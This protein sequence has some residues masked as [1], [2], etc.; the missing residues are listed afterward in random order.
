MV[1]VTV[2]KLEADRQIVGV[3]QRELTQ[4]SEQASDRITRW[5]YERVA[6]VKLISGL[7]TTAQRDQVRR[8]AIDR[9][10]SLYPI[11]TGWVGYIDNNCKI[12]LGSAGLREGETYDESV[13]QGADSSSYLGEV[14]T[15][16]WI[17]GGTVENPQSTLFLPMA[18]PVFDESGARVGL[19]AMEIRTTYLDELLTRVPLTVADGHPAR[20]F[21]V[22]KDTKTVVIG[23]ECAGTP[24]SDA[25]LEGLGNRSAEMNLPWPDRDNYITGSAPSRDFRDVAN[26][27]W[28]MV[29]RADRESALTLVDD[30]TTRL[31]L[32]GGA[33]SVCSIIMALLL[34]KSLGRPLE[35]LTAAAANNE[36]QE[37]AIRTAANVRYREISDLATALD[38]RF[39][40]LQKAHTATANALMDREALLKEVHHRVKNNLQV[41]ISLMRL[42]GSRIKGNPD[43][44]A[45][46]DRLTSRVQVIGWLYSKLYERAIFE[47]IPA[48]SLLEPLVAVIQDTYPNA[49]SLAVR[50]DI[51][52]LSL[53]FDQTLILGMLTIEVVTNAFQHAYPR[54]GRDQT[55]EITLSRTGENRFEYT[56]C[57]RGVGFDTTK[58]HAGIGL[59]MAGRMATQLGDP[60]EITSNESGTAVRLAFEIASD[61]TGLAKVA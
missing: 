50:T 22:S 29:A 44:K 8:Y 2:M 33:L 52:D 1:A 5:L 38:Q 45:V 36:A 30:L 32:W 6:D 39:T 14:R 41:I 3:V 23:G 46:V 40:E 15:V 11:S 7:V 21:I 31:I 28:T 17:D 10:A 24:V 26:L 37:E 25:F 18:V 16:P 55:V 57:D 56:V 54:W 27:N 43:G 60:I 13:C 58:R 42:Q 47:N 51:C 20:V 49:G 9:T 59:T 61:A 48:R 12:L 35:L 4:V 53:D 19:V 34:A